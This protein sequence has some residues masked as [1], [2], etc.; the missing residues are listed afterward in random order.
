MHGEDASRDSHRVHTFVYTQVCTYIGETRFLTNTSVAAESTLSSRRLRQP[1]VERCTTLHSSFAYNTP[2]VGGT[3][4]P[5]AFVDEIRRE[6]T[7][8]PAAAALVV[9]LLVPVRLSVSPLPYSDRLT[10]LAFSCL[11][12]SLRSTE[13]VRPHPSSR[14]D[15]RVALYGRTCFF[16]SS[17]F[18]VDHKRASARASVPSK[19]FGESVLV[20]SCIRV[21]SVSTDTPTTFPVAHVQDATHVYECDLVLPIVPACIHIYTQRFRQRLSTSGRLLSVGT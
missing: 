17:H 16:L 2:L 9:F 5:V 14:W 8:A 20:C 13:S 3:E 15:R 11:F 18:L 10:L 21:N 4:G 12:A 19:I 1:G 7:N 6:R